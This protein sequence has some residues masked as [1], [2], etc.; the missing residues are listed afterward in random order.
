MEVPGQ[1][2]GMGSLFGIHLTDRPVRCYRDAAAVDPELRRR[3]FLGLLNEGVLLASQLVGCV[4]AP[5]GP[6]EVD[7]LVGALRRVLGRVF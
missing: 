4:T 5:M 6:A 7:V 3:V 1:V 2:T